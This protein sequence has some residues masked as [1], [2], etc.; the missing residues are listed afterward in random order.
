MLNVGFNSMVNTN[1]VIAIADNTKT[2]APIR[3]AVQDAGARGQ[4]IDLTCG[5]R[6]GTVF[7]MDNGDVVLVAKTGATLKKHFED[8]RG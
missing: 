3:R 6:T 5:R 1:R 4:L 8:R 7:F 2:S